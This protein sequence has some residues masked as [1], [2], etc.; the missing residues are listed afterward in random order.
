MYSGHVHGYS[1]L[2]PTN[3]PTSHIHQCPAPDSARPVLVD[4]SSCGSGM[5]LTPG[6]A[7]L[8]SQLIL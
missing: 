5:S 1:D 3:P 8:H 4:T 7:R 2:P 6:R